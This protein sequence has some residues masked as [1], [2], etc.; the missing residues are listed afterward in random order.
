M[1]DDLL[2]FVQQFG[3]LFVAL[4]A[5]AVQDMVIIPT[6]LQQLD[7]LLPASL[8][9]LLDGIPQT[10]EPVP[11]GE[12][13]QSVLGPLRAKDLLHVVLQDVP[14]PGREGGHD[15]KHQKQGMWSR[16]EK[17]GGPPRFTFHPQ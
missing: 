17:L 15:R 8:D 2:Y 13:H 1:C 16:V 14:L 9:V 7:Q 3:D 10:S 4:R 12:Q 11:T 5:L 6:G